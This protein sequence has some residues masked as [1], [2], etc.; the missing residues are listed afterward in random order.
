MRSSQKDDQSGPLLAQLF[1][2][3]QPISFFLRSL[4]FLLFKIEF[5]TE[6][7]EGNEGVSM[8]AN[9]DSFFSEQA[10]C[11]ESCQRLLASLHGFS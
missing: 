8:T 5:R 1:Q 9:P 4:C 10:E 2:E 3:L 11:L 7:N 6:A